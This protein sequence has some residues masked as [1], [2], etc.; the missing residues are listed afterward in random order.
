MAANRQGKAD[1]RV[2]T[3]NEPSRSL[4]E[5]R[6]RISRAKARL[7]DRLVILA[8]HYQGDDVIEFADFVGDSLKLSRQAANRSAARYIVFCGVRFMAET[9]DVLSYPYQTVFLPNPDAGCP[10]A[11]MAD[12]RQ[13]RPCWKT[14][15]TLWDDKV[16]PITYI[17]SSAEL[18]AF[19]GRNGGTV[20]TSSNAA[21]VMKWAFKKSRRLLFFPDQYLGRNTGLSLGLPPEAI[22]VWDPEAESLLG[23]LDHTRLILWNGFCPLHVD[24]TP[25]HA[26]EVRGRYP[27]VRVIVHPECPHEVVRSADDAGSTE[28]IIECIRSSE[29]GSRWA[30][31][32]DIRL[33]RRLARRHPEKEI[34]SLAESVPPCLDM[35]KI[36]PLNLLSTLQG[37]LEGEAEGCVRVKTE[38]AMWARVALERMLVIT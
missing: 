6:K 35:G 1:P 23:D 28:H 19:C 8:H 11:D 3:E 30:V 20:C 13:V 26:E 18:K 7:G 29:P 37:L 24:F 5:T 9:A 21:A 12:L 2:L 32:T 27:G 17:N 25:R 34:F 36:K 38:T 16:T 31:G 15:L 14:L 10:M 22:S 4:T 33:V